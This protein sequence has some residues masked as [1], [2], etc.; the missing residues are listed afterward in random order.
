MAVSNVSTCKKKREKADEKL[1]CVI[2]RGV[3]VQPDPRSTVSFGLALSLQL[4]RI[5]ISGIKRVQP[6]T[7]VN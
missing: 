1:L 2:S 5:Y 6:R 4:F 3:C 7:N